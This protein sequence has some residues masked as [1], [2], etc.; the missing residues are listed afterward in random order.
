MQRQI[1]RIS[2]MTHTYSAKINKWIAGRLILLTYLRPRST[3]GAGLRKE[4]ALA[5]LPFLMPV[6]CAPKSKL[7]GNLNRFS[8]GRMYFLSSRQ[9]CQSTHSSNELTSTTPSQSM[10]LVLPWSTDS[11]PM[12]RMSSY[13]HTGSLLSV[14]KQPQWAQVTNKSESNLNTHS[15]NVLCVNSIKSQNCS[16]HVVIFIRFCKT[17]HGIQLST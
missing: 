16:I 4:A 2:H 15:N 9:Q 1:I 5:T 6:T 7:R 3:H 17:K 14:H 13:L 8:S 12:D 11:L 10:D